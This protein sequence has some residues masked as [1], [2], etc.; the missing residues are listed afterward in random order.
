MLMAA[1]LSAVGD[2]TQPPGWI[3]MHG[4]SQ[5]SCSGAF[6]AEIDGRSTKPKVTGSNP[7]GRAAR[8]GCIWRQIGRCPASWSNGLE[9]GTRHFG[10]L[11]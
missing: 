8:I 2:R 1:V 4:L 9:D 3:A 5:S 7:V 10:F 11:A 6:G